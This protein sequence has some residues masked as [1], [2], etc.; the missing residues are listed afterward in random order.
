M[1]KVFKLIFCT[2]LAFIFMLNVN[3]EC[4][5]KELNDWASKVE[6]KFTLI[7]E[8]G[9][10]ASQYAYLLSLDNPRN[11]IRFTVTD[12]SLGT[13]DAREITVDDKT[14]LYAV[15][16]YTNLEDETYTIDIFGDVG[17]ACEGEHIK[18]IKY[19]VPR[20][21]EY[22]K[23]RICTGNDSEYCKAFTNI[24]KDMTL[25]EFEKKVEET[26]PSS[27]PT[28]RLWE[29]L[30]EYGLYILIPLVLVSIYYFIKIDKFKQEER[31]R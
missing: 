27:K 23:Q 29:I 1:K 6:V 4:A 26:T 18:S 14:K 19:T 24:T 8:P 22:M 2:V 7:S 25:E 5:D 20:Y 3:A 11:D 21:N 15:G 13:A 31:D 28:G 17:S 9:Y 10:D 12:G 16:C 30:K